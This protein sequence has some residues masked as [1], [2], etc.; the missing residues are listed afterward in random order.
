[1]L[2]R[3][4]SLQP[5]LLNQHGRTSIDTPTLASRQT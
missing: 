5:E 2:L 1:L 3:P 4:A